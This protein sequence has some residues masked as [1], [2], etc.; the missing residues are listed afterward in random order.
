MSNIQ[1]QF[2]SLKW[3]NPNDKSLINQIDEKRFKN[4]ETKECE[5]C[6]KACGDFFVL[7]S[8]F[9]KKCRN[10]YY[11]VLRRPTLK[12]IKKIRDLIK[13]VDNNKIIDKLLSLSES[14]E[15]Q[16]EFSTY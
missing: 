4:I 10:F 7:G 8:R 5:C 16:N 3:I 11:H 2:F 12:N 6:N 14:N 9:C 15:Y 13:H 1:I